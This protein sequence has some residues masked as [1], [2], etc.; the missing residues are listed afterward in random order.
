MK[1]ILIFGCISVAIF[2]SGFFFQKLNFHLSNLNKLEYS[3]FLSRGA[4]LSLA[5]F[6]PLL[7]LT[8]CKHFITYIRSHS[9]FLRKYFPDYTILIHKVLGTTVVINVIIHT[10]CHYINFYTAEKLRLAYTDDIHHRTYAG[11]SGHIMISSMMIMIIFSIRFFREKYYEIFFYTHHLYIFVYAAFIFHSFGCFVKTNSGVC[12]P[13]YS[14]YLYAIPLM[15]YSGEKIYDSFKK[16]V[17]I[18]SVEQVNV[19]CKIKFKRCLEYR[20]GQYINI[21]VPDIN[22]FTY[23]PFTIT[24]CP[25]IENE[26]MTVAIKNSGNWTSKFK[27]LLGNSPNIKLKI[28]GPFASPCDKIY[29]FEAAIFVSTGIGITPFVSL[30]KDIANKYVKG[31]LFLKKID[32]IFINNRNDQYD[33]FAQEI[34]TVTDLIPENV[35]S[36]NIFLTEKFLKEEIVL[37][38]N[39]D[40]TNFKYYQGTKIPINYG[41]PDFNKIFKKYIKDGY[42]R[43]VGV[44]SCSNE[45]TNNSI[46]KSCDIVNSKNISFSFIKEPF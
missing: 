10:V 22:R 1:Y 17:T 35:L 11:I 8:S 33:W 21:N 24:S 27:T 45:S 16:E 25:D 34:K 4:G 37:I 13:Y 14:I 18:E 6:F 41:R 20:C 19:I 46:S 7:V 31:E 2:T 44:F 12:V 26:F 29:D 36:F 5:V 15:I 30:L 32:V 43:N 9:K 23:H 42:S 28:S 38:S 3:V 39:D 40:L